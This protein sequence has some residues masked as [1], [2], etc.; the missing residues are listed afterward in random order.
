M[1]HQRLPQWRAAEQ[2]AACRPP[3]R[4]TSWR[5]M[6]EQ[7]LQR[8]RGFLH[9]HNQPLGNLCT[10]GKP[11]LAASAI[12]LSA[13]LHSLLFDVPTT[14]SAR[15]CRYDAVIAPASGRYR[16]MLLGSN[17]AQ[18]MHAHVLET[19]SHRGHSTQQPRGWQ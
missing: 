7:Q 18:S 3:W 11:I 14:T 19:R 16:N 4:G 5:P 2:A 6:P 10:L 8:T 17:Q 1:A 12:T 9:M 13:P 15:F